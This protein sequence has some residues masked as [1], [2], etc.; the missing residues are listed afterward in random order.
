MMPP[1]VTVCKGC[2]SR[3]VGCHGWCQAYL[4]QKSALD[5]YNEQVRANTV[6]DSYR[7]ALTIKN[8]DRYRKTQTGYSRYGRIGRKNM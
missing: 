5:A 6:Y 8:S 3:K 1:K 4:D 2:S 7:E